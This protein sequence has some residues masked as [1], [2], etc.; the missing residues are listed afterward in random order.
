MGLADGSEVVLRPLTHADADGV[1]AFLAGL[2]AETRRLSTFDGYDL[3]A[4]RELCDAIARYDKL[5][6]V[7]AEVPSGRIAGLL[8][9]SL[10]LHPSDMS[11]TARPVSG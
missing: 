2:S 3:A 8:E 6:P 11:A 1:A 5:R 7:L 4:A 10:D 9:I